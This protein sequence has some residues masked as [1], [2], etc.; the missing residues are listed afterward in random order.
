MANVAFGRITQLVSVDSFRLAPQSF[1]TPITV[2]LILTP[3][4]QSGLSFKLTF[5]HEGSPTRKVEGGVSKEVL[6]SAFDS[7][8]EMSD[9]DLEKS[10]SKFMEEFSGD[11]SFH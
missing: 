1:C 11:P 2:K 7:F 4:F 3:P 9:E 5:G 10:T 6:R 8:V